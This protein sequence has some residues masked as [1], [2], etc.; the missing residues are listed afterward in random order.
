MFDMR[1]LPNAAAALLELTDAERTVLGYVADGLSP[2]EIAERLS[3]DEDELYRLVAWVLDELQP[4]PNGETMR[5][6]HARHASRAANPADLAEFERRFGASLPPD[7][8]G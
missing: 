5:D 4:A 3:V 6:A 1:T 2:R 7:D 8:E